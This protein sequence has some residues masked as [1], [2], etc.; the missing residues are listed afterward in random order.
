MG[1]EIKNTVEI[2]IPNVN[3]FFENFNIFLPICL[4]GA[5]VDIIF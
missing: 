2:I 5:K 3:S 4:R 1:I